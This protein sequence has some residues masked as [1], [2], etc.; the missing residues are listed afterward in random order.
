MRGGLDLADRPFPRSAA[1]VVQLAATSGALMLL[2]FAALARLAPEVRRGDLLPF[3]EHY[4]VAEVRLL[5]AKVY[6][7]TSSGL[8]D[9]LTVGALAAVALAF[10]L[11]WALLARRGSARASVFA[12]AAVG[13]AFLAADDL[14]AAHETLGHNL[15]FLASLPL[16]DHPD[17]VIVGL[18]GL[19]VLGFGRRHRALAAGTP[20]WP[21]VVCFAAGAFAV[22]HDLLPLG[23]SAAEE[24]AE[25]LAGL[26][27]LTGVWMIAAGQL[28]ADQL[29]SSAPAWRRSAS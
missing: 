8:A 13:A 17:D 2:T 12:W 25:V 5:G 27:L 3:F 19:V 24:G 9:L 16:I 10:G 21:W 14:L 22:A 29:S 20:R 1:H 7:D 6:V 11:C 4:E 28:R 23:L 26:A 15:G 18:Y